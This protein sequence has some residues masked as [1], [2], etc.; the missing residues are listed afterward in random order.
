MRCSKQVSQG[1][2]LDKN[3]RMTSVS[4]EARHLWQSL[5]L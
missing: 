2:G 1:F 5:N 4:G 3:G